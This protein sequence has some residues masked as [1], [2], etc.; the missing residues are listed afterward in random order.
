MDVRRARGLQSLSQ[1][2]SASYYHSKER[3]SD[4]CAEEEPKEAYDHRRILKEILACDEKPVLVK[5][6][7]YHTAG[8]M[9]QEFVRRFRNTFIIREPRY[10]LASLYK[11]WPDFTSEEAG[12]ENLY[13]RFEYALKEGQEPVVVEASDLSE[14]PEGTVAASLREAWHPTQAGGPLLGATKVPEWQMWEGW[15]DA[16]QQSTGIG[17]ISH[18]EAMLPSELVEVYNRCLPYYEALHERR[19]RPAKPPV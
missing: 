4:R 14:N 3:R 8:F 10:V 6:M 11:M 18:E 15:H 19:L 17:K 7:A 16:Q 2:F 1:P 12:Y 9:T 5:D 13:D